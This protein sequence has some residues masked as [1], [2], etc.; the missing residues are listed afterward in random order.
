MRWL[1]EIE[2]TISYL[3]ILSQPW[4]RDPTRQ[5][6]LS[7]TEFNK[8]FHVLDIDGYRKLQAPIRLL[9]LVV[10]VLKIIHPLGKVPPH[11]LLK[12]ETGRL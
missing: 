9:A 12:S 5:F 2:F 10:S 1:E 8:I 6:C 11:R 3:K 4:K 7:A